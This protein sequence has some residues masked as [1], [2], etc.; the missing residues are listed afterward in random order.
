[1]TTKTKPAPTVSHVQTKRCCMCYGIVQEH[2][3]ENQEHG[4]FVCTTGSYISGCIHGAH[5][6]YGEA[7][8][9][10][11]GG[12]FEEQAK[13]E[14]P[15]LF[16]KFQESK[17]SESKTCSWKLN[18]RRYTNEVYLDAVTSCTDYNERKLIPGGYDQ[19]WKYCPHCGKEIEKVK[20]DV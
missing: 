1:M 6:R 18:D 17:R 4:V 10:E 11:H 2:H 14:Q 7:G 5:V 3:Y 19:N 12:D 16:K 15:E 8:W 20:N 9:A 13:N